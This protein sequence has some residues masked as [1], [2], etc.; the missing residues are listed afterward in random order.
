MRRAID[1]TPLCGF[2]VCYLNP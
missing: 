1:S 2:V